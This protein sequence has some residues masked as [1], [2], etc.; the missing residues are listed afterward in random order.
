[1]RR[2]NKILGI[3]IVS[4]FMIV[5]DI[6]IVITALPK[7]QQSLAFSTTGLSWVQNAY[8]LSF[9]GLLLL[10]ARAGD[11]LGRRRLFR[12]GLTCFTGASLAIGLAP[13]AA[14]L[15]VARVLQGISA[16]CLAPASL[17]LLSTTFPDGAERNRAVSWYA[18]AAGVGGMVGLVLGG[19]FAGSFSWR[20]GFL[21]NV[22]VG[23]ALLMA[24]RGVL[25][26]TERQPGHFDV[27][28]ALSSTLGMT[29]LVYGIV[30][31]ADSG[32]GDRATLVSLS[33]GALMLAAFVWVEARAR[34]PILPLRLFASRA[35]SGAYAA[36]LLYLGGMMSFWFFSTQYLQQVL[37]FEPLRAGLAFLP[38]SAVNLVATLLLSR[39]IGRFG[40]ARVLAGGVALTLCGM[41]WLARVSMDSSY[42]LSVALP[43]VLIGAGQGCTLGP[44]TVTGIAGVPPQD[45]GAA[46]GL[47]NV[48][49]QVGGALGVAALVVVFSAANGDG[50]LEGR[51]LLAHRI[52]A[53]LTGS[54]VLLAVALILVVTLVVRPR[55]LD[56]N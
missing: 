32:W 23:I 14:T 53:A 45:N 48:A 28:G 31:A 13:T 24:A 12:I 22:P 26:E 41:A 44:L 35:R 43:F 46:S 15:L 38:M 1:M 30:R 16:A 11:V 25:I 55:R 27:A 6:S 33:V 54:T 3:V 19:L 50:A 49:H 47:V 18:A 20:L 8:T 29:A 37:D 9:G 5:L 21:V 4:Y 39:F 36:R 51:A 56:R 52:T 40:V 7:I 10:G 34:Q 42:L 2:S 17:A